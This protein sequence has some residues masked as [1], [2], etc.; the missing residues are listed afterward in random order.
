MAM[1]TE[2]SS[3]RRL[4]RPRVTLKLATSLDGKIATKS[5][6]SKWITGPQARAQVHEMRAAHDCVLSGI[7]TVMADDPLLTARTYPPPS[8]QPLRAILDSGARTPSTAKLLASL[9]QGP[10]CFFHDHDFRGSKTGAIHYRVERGEG[11]LNLFEVLDTL[12]MRHDVG[13]L[14]VEAG[15]K[16]AGAF[17][18]AGLV[19]EIVWF[20]APIIIGGDGLCVF[21]ALGVDGLGDA[22]A[23]SCLNTQVIGH[24]RVETY[25]P[26]K[27]AT[28]EAK[29]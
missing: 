9:D 21:D 11:G 26:A 16:L 12:V 8:R 19:D 27:D 23:F 6:A 10:V 4:S 22:F 2:T 1:T 29:G 17:L 5:G 18:K 7:G 14:M 24:D 28:L 25:I 20:R 13:S 3:V 15:R